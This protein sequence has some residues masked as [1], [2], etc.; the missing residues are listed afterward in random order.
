MILEP[1]KPQVLAVRLIPRVDP[2]LKAQLGLRPD[3]DSVG[4]L[5]CTS[6]DALY[7]ALDEG[8]KAAKVEVVYAKSFYAGASH[9]SGPFSGEVIGIFAAQDPDTVSSALQAAIAYLESKAWF[10]SGNQAGT[11]AFFPHVIPSVGRYL[12]KLAGV[13]PGTAMAYLIAPPIEAL[14]GLDAALKAADVQMKVF[15]A[16]PSETNFAGGL[17]VGDVPS[18]EA[19]AAA[20]QQ[21]V[22]ELAKTPQQLTP[23]QNVTLLTEKF[24]KP[25]ERPNSPAALPY[26]ILESGME[27]KSKPDGYT[28]LFTNASL[29][30]KNHP[31]I[32]FRGELD[33]FQAQV[34]EAS[35]ACHS[36][37]L[38][39]LVSDLKDVLA[40]LRAIMASEVTGK[41]MPRLSVGGMDAEEL[42]RISHNT[43]KFL[44]IGWVLPDAT[45]G[46][47]ISKLNLLRA[48]CR[49]VE[50]EAD[51]AFGDDSHLTPANRDS[52]MH[53]L[54]RLSNALYV[55]VCKA[56][57]LRRPP[58]S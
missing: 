52:L 18:V 32:R 5:T 2:Q 1:I 55:L 29:V 4:L 24:G 27:L 38:L 45:M 41:P 47:A 53:G 44:G 30:K 46:P 58:K 49:H 19:A 40:Y 7:T 3:Q 33:L 15:Y 8:T 9:A 50:L 51:A 11:L 23:A 56:L 21:T 6:D 28:H 17:L 54:N 20:F 36:E 48:T 26:R 31:A 42:H 57:A 25:F 37:G 10:Y 14:L 13:E 39:P 43:A 12:G 34:I 35:V 22:L 16:P